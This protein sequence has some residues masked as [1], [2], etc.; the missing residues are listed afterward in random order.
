MKICFIGFF[1]LIKNKENLVFLIH[2]I[3][4]FRKREKPRNQ[5]HESY[6]ALPELTRKALMESLSLPLHR[7]Q[8]RLSDIVSM[9]VGV[10]V[11]R[12]GQGQ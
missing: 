9:N 7:K 8:T 1:T 4:D 5:R 10:T 3:I 12:R 11:N 6:T 2:L